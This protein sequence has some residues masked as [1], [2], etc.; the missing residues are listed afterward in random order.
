[1][2]GNKYKEVKRLNL[3]EIDQEI[4]TFWKENSIF[5][6][7]VNT[8]DEN[9]P[10]VF[11]E[12]PPSANGMPGIHHA[13]ARSIKDLF[14]RF[15]TMQGYRVERKGGWDTHGLPIELQVEKK[16][17]IK[18]DDIGTKIS[19]EDYNKECR[20]EVL[21]FKDS[22]DDLTLKMGYWVDL[23][24][25]YIT[26][27]NTYIE[28][29]W[30]LLKRLYDKDLLYKGYTVQPYSPAAGTGLSSHELNMPG[31][32]KNVTDTTVV[33]QFKA[34][35]KTLPLAFQNAKTQEVFF[36]AWTTTPWT[37][38]SNT[39]LTVGSN[40]K[41]ALVS[42]LNQYTNE[43]IN[44]ILAED[45]INYQ[46][47]GKYQQVEDIT[48]L[49]E[50]LGKKLPYQVLETLTGK[51]LVGSKYDQLFPWA[52]PM[53]NPE[54]AFQVIDG[55]FVTTSDGT[56]I[57]HTAPTFGSDDY[58]VAKK[59]GVPGMLVEI[60]ENPAPL[61][62]LQGKFV[63][64]ASFPEK[65]RG[66]YVKNEYYASGEAP[67]RSVDVELAILL[68]EQNRAFKVQKY[69]HNYP[70]CW[71]TD[72]PVLYYPL[73]SWF[74]RTT[75][76]KGRMAELNRTINWKP[77]AT[78][79]G[80]FGNWLDNLVDWNLSR[81]RFWGTPLPIWRTK[82]GTEEICIG[83]VEELKAE[84]A[85]A[86]AAGIETDDLGEEFDLHKPY[87]DRI[88]L[89][90]SKGEPM[91]READLIDVWFDSGAMPYAQLHW[92]FENEDKINT[93]YQAD[94]IA[95]GVD[96]TRGWFFTLHAIA[97]MLFDRVA[98]KNVVSNGLVLDKKGNKM[99]KSKGNAVN[100]FETIEKFGADATRWYMISNS[101]PWDNLKFDTDGIG[102]TQRKLFGTLFNTY[103]FFALYANIDGFEYK[104]ED[105][106]LE[107]RPEIDRWVLS[108]LNTLVTDVTEALE[109][110]EPTK[111]ARMV[112]DFVLDNL[113]NWY[114]RLCR[115][116]FWKGEYNEDKVSAY[117]TLYT[118]LTTITK[119]MAPIAPFFSDYL[120][121]N[122]NEV[123]DKEQ[124]ES[125]HLT[126]FPTVDNNLINKEL[127]ERMNLAQDASSL[128]LSLRKREDIKVRQP[129]SKILI[130]IESDHQKAQL[131]QVKTLILSEVN[132][133]ELEYITDTSGIVKK[134]IKPNFK[135]L[136]KKLGPKM[137][138][139]ASAF[140]Q[141]G[142]EEI[143]T[144]EK[145]GQLNIQLDSEAVTI[146]RDEVEITTADVEGWLVANT[147]NVTV[148]LDIQIDE[149]LRNEGHAREFINRIQ[150]IRKES[151][152]DVTDRISIQI[153]GDQELL[154]A[155]Q[156]FDN[157][158]Q[159]EVLAEKISIYTEQIDG[160]KV[161]VNNL[162]AHINVE[163]FK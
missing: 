141:F 82:D 75:A 65:F 104:E 134:S 114:V 121:K 44:V 9:N 46:F 147:D 93:V 154:S 77:E 69:E 155:I 110:Y 157:F 149:N 21:K 20:E 81:S 80:R 78:G 33:A 5:E 73:D 12:G 118:C 107:N 42:T 35:E 135:V 58:M 28:T 18:K 25:P 144:I 53:E 101:Q 22:W 125:V 1:M 132:V 153:S 116:R 61:V 139:V 24:N 115:R 62:N 150:N 160:N 6:K 103:S 123:T 15:K 158:I 43:A 138:Q 54:N 50:D 137:K 89:V 67:E 19:V 106:A 87:V 45:L 92:P 151:D 38:P 76:M 66:A 27:E 130:P 72:K 31:C 127:E 117:Q 99:S 60:N 74:V 95:E 57:V 51:E 4:L 128:V 64:L 109:D 142:Q 34:K 98:F 71:R 8:K 13:M 48:N 84:I 119:L 79:S 140:A 91:Y 59:H 86:K 68:K 26:Y 7:S 143:Q 97:T 120:F 105:I 129:L 100:P 122:L 159:A 111:A 156:Q 112:Q 85:K 37:L 145:E 94:F 16:L 49:P 136:G 163:K 3:P 2:S 113:S 10:F 30:N 148:A 90:S 162:E 126:N 70:H 55:D 96:Q 17:G 131:E 83:S 29:L 23:E 161:E 47:A 63:D 52:T 146:L 39:A 41:Y 36:L 124:V 56:G 40:I 152:F 108:L 14:C 32:Y 102:E 88:V 133:K 11:F